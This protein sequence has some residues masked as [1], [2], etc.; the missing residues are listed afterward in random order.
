MLVGRQIPSTAKTLVLKLDFSLHSEIRSA[1]FLESIPCQRL[2]SLYPDSSADFGQ[3]PPNSIRLPLLEKFLC[4]VEVSA[5]L[6]YA[7]VVPR[8]K[9]F[10]G[11][12]HGLNS[13]LHDASAGASGKFNSVDHLELHGKLQRHGTISESVV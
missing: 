5:A 4:G 10:E 1:L 9:H 2:T 3:L 6:V 11:H 7:I 13:S 8:L 12:W